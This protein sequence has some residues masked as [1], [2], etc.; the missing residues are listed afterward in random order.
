[1]LLSE[2]WSCIKN[3]IYVHVKSVA[4]KQ[5]WKKLAESTFIKWN[6]GF[7]KHEIWMWFVCWT[8]LRTTEALVSPFPVCP[9]SLSFIAPLEFFH[10]YHTPLY[11][12]EQCGLFWQHTYWSDPW[13]R[14]KEKRLSQFLL[15]WTVRSPDYHECNIFEICGQQATAYTEKAK[16]K[17]PSCLRPM[18]SH[19]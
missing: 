5:L 11:L 17:C 7:S 14:K 18:Y 15:Q 13:E 4:C 10:Q 1:M 16:C 6:V 9:P 8:V 19:S 12:Q 3:Y 2:A